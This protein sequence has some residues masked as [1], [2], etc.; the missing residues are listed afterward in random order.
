MKLDPG[1][2]S[3]DARTELR[4]LLA[5]RPVAVDDGVLEA[6]WSLEDRYSL[7]F[8]DALI[9]AAA[10]SA[11]CERLLSEDFTDGETYGGVEVVN[12]FRH[13]PPAP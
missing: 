2:S 5:W 3:H 11:G 7:S 4:S 6:A 10:Q 8:W 12:P 13:Q 1:L 9:V